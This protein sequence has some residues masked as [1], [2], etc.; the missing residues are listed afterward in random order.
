[1][2]VLT[3]VGFGSKAGLVPLHAW[4]PRAHPEA[5]SHV[6]A[7]MSAAM[8]NLGVY[9]I[10]RVGFDLLGGGP[11]WWWLLVLAVGAVSAVYGILQAA[12]AT[13]LKRLLA[14]STT[15][16]MGLIFLGAGCGGIVRRRRRARCWP[17]LAMAAA[18]LHVINHAAFKTLLFLAA[19]S[20]L[21]ATG[22]ATWTRWAGCARRMPAT[23][24]L[25][26]VAALGASALPLGTGVRQRMAAAAVPG[27][28]RA[29]ATTRW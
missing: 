3:L 26:G 25:F 16:N 12:V 10:V 7:L 27:P 13:D 18:L 1:M 9:G 8:V 20:V 29:P 19:G 5:P 6:S 11:R 24:A 28:R 22:C 14:Y 21:R 17:P 23:T 4:L 2:F 15:E